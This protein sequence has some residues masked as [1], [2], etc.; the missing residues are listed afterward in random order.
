MGTEE[1]D[2]K[3]KKQMIKLWKKEEGRK[4]KRGGEVERRGRR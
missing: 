4:E 3:K 2:T 1:K